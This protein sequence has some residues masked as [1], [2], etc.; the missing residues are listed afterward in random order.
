M[1]KIRIHWLYPS[2]KEKSTQISSWRFTGPL[3]SQDIINIQVFCVEGSCMFSSQWVC[4]FS[5]ET[6]LK[7]LVQALHSVDLNTPC[8]TVTHQ[9]TP[10]ATIML[11]SEMFLRDLCGCWWLQLRLSAL[12]IDTVRPIPSLT[13]IILLTP[14]LLR[15]GKMRDDV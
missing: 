12:L 13:C 6:K 14:R 2:H 9:Q 5:F 4:L 15:K 8:T 10:H 1:P 11:R 3:L 7:F